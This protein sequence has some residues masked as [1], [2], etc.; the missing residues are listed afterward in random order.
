MPQVIF[1]DPE[2]A[3]VGKTSDQLRDEGVEV[4]VVDV[5]MSSAAGAGLLAKGYVG[6]A[7]LVIDRP[8]QVILGATFVGSDVTGRPSAFQWSKPPSSR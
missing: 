7:R 5:E 6:K 1:T 2:V 4:D 8:R 3:A